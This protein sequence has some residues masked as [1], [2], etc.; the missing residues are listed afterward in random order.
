[1]EDRTKQTIWFIQFLLSLKNS[2][3]K[4]QTEV[5]AILQTVLIKFQ[6]WLQTE[7]ET[8][9]IKFANNEI[10]L[11]ELYQEEFRLNPNMTRKQFRY[12]TG[13][14]FMSEVRKR[15]RDVEGMCRIL[16]IMMHTQIRSI[17][18]YDSAIDKIKRIES[19]MTYEPRR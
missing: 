3:T 10:E 2:Q 1:M 13:K 8:H 19:S 12:F 7:L 9:Q 17:H 18:E 15:F 16:G 5:F 14:T 11:D 6:T 4:T